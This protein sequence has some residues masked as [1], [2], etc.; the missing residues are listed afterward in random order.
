MLCTA[1]TG[2]GRSTTDDNNWRRH[3]GGGYGAPTKRYN[4]KPQQADQRDERFNNGSNK[5]KQDKKTTG[6]TGRLRGSH[7]T[8][9]RRGQW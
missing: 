8:V 1:R 4:D 5:D 2:R 3:G 6:G 9:K 7:I